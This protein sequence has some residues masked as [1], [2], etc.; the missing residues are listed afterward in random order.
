MIHYRS[1]S[2][3]L[4]LCLIIFISSSVFGDQMM[5]SGDQSKSASGPDSPSM[6]QPQGSDS[7]NV[8][9]NPRQNNT[10][11]LTGDNNQKI[12]SRSGE[13]P[14]GTGQRGSGT[15]SPGPTQTISPVI[16][17]SMITPSQPDHQI[18]G[19]STPTPETRIISPEPTHTIPP[20]VTPTVITP[21]QPDNRIPDINHPASP[22]PKQIEEPGSPGYQNHERNSDNPPVLKGS[23]QVI[24][25]PTGAMVYLN[26]EYKGKTPSQGY[27]DISD[28]NPGTYYLLL[29]LSGYWDYSSTVTVTGGEI[30]TMNCIL[31]VNIPQTATTGSLTLQ[32]SP[33][34]SGISQS[35]M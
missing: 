4:F 18:P 19:T 14:G 17:P 15:I 29:R 35:D 12:L 33:I 6:I 9:D 20:V 2:T 34:N 13:Q 32:S 3:L 11:L 24:S 7:Q 1:L 28:L 26:N 22:T 10:T 25:N 23:I 8:S 5:I 16:T 31:S 27:M 30:E 21:S